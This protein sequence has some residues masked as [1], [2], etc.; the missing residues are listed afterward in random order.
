MNKLTA[1]LNNAANYAYVL[2]MG[3]RL[4]T[5]IVDIITLKKAK[6]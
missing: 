4:T 2:W 5:M 6:G 3:L 1:R